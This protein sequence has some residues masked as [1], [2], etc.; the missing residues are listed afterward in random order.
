MTMQ[1]YAFYDFLVFVDLRFFF[2]GLFDG[3]QTR[4]LL[5]TVSSTAL[6]AMCYV[7]CGIRDRQKCCSFDISKFCSCH[8]RYSIDCNEVD[9]DVW[10]VR[11]AR[12]S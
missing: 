6:S 11:I 2:G 5:A 4:L 1:Q 10:N 8:R 3:C 9:Y 7:L 12:A